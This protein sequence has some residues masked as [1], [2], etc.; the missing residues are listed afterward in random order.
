MTRNSKKHTT[1][2][3]ANEFA[4]S[5]LSESNDESSD[6]EVCFEDSDY[7]LMD[8][9]DDLIYD[10]YVDEEAEAGNGFDFEMED[11]SNPKSPI[12]FDDDIA[13]DGDGELTHV[14]ENGSEMKEGF[15]EFNVEE[16]MDDPVFF[17][18]LKFKSFDEFKEAAKHYAIRHKRNMGLSIMTS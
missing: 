8:K 3:L 16:N 11:A 5:A 12:A 17:D 1:R 6:F 18:G 14:V 7:D 4:D 9:E 15:P 13:Y 10:N 2:D